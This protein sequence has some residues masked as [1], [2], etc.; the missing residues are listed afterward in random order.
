MGG[1]SGCLAHAQRREPLRLRL[2]DGF[3]LV[4]G[5]Y[6]RDIIFAFKE[7]K[8]RLDLQV[9][10]DDFFADRQGKVGVIEGDGNSISQTQATDSYDALTLCQRELS[11]HGRIG[12]HNLSAKYSSGRLA[13]ECMHILHKAT[14]FCK[15]LG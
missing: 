14:E 1:R 15:L 5:F 11:K 9:V 12:G 6:Q 4:L 2:A 10:G 3:Q 8:D 7:R 13:A